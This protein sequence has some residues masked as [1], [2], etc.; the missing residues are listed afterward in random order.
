MFQ[1]TLAQTPL[2]LTS[3]FLSGIHPL[4]SIWLPSKALL[5][6]SGSSIPSLLPLLFP[7][8][9]LKTHSC[10]VFTISEAPASTLLPLPAC[11]LRTPAHDLDSNLRSQ[12]LAL[13]FYLLPNPAAVAFPAVQLSMRSL[14][15]VDQWAAGANA[16][17]SP[18][19]TS[20]PYTYTHTHIDT[21]MHAHTPQGGNRW[22]SAR[23]KG[24]GGLQRAGL[25]VCLCESRSVS[26]S[27]ASYSTIRSIQARFL[28]DL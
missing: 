22:G 25:G 5:P 8:P 20:Y 1:H 9:Q 4:L 6:I 15:A 14:A 27:P 2:Y 13:S 17:L 21:Q 11:K 12:P 19:L 24:C 23:G 3:L 7:F 28:C 18:P 10:L 16:C 26:V